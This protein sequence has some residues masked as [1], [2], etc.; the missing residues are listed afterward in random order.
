MLSAETKTQHTYGFKNSTFSSLKAS[1]TV[2]EMVWICHGL[3]KIHKK[4][5]AI[6]NS[7][8]NE[9]NEFPTKD[10]ADRNCTHSHTDINNMRLISG[11]TWFDADIIEKDKN[12]HVLLGF[13]L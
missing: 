10:E 2:T 9:V 11:G 1:H 13:D 8:L 6:R 12:G 7:I 5:P 3:S 4:I